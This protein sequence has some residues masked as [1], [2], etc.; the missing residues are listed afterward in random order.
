MNY[1][2]KKNDFYDNWHWCWYCPDWPKR[3]YEDNSIKPSSRVCRYCFS[4]KFY[5]VNRNI[6]NNGHHEVHRIGQ[7]FRPDGSYGF[8]EHLPDFDNQ[9]SLGRH[10]VCDSAVA[11][12]KRLGYRTANGCYWCS[13]ECHTG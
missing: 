11:E 5:C 7:H 10:D 2:K 6:D 12:A 8:C 9:L 3:D 1:R 4:M 13:R